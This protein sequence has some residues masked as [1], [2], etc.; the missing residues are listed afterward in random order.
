MGNDLRS[1]LDTS[2]DDIPDRHLDDAYMKK[3][4]MDI[5]SNCPT[6]TILADFFINDEVIYY[7]CDSQRKKKLRQLAKEAWEEKAIIQKQRDE[8]RRKFRI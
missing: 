1:I 4:M 2:L 7:G 3:S 5:A 8:L 6:P